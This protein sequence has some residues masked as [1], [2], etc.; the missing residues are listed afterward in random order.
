MARS[1]GG[2]T[3]YYSLHA[4]IP[5]A[6][7]SNMKLF[8]TA[9]ALDAL[10]ADYEY[11]TYLTL[12]GP[13]E[14]G[15]LDGHLWVTGRGDPS[16]SDR[17][18]GDRDAMMKRWAAELKR[19]GIRHV[20]GSVVGDDDYFDDVMRHPE[21]KKSHYMEWYGA[22]V[23][24]L[25]FNDNCLRVYWKP[26]PRVNAPALYS[27]DPDVSAM[28]LVN[29]MKT[30][31]AKGT[32][33]RSYLPHV[34][35]GTAEALGSI[36]I[37]RKSPVSDWVPVD[38]PTQFFAA[39]FRAVLV[40]EG[41]TV[42]GPGVD[43][44]DAK[45]K[46]G[47]DTPVRRVAVHKSPT[48]SALVRV[49]NRHSQNFYA[50]MLLKTVGRERQKMGS[51][52]AGRKAVGEFMKRWKIDS[53]GFRQED[54]S[55]LAATNAVTP[56]QFVDLLDVMD[57]HPAAEAFRDSLPV[58]GERGGSL[59]TRFQ[60]TREQKALASS[61]AAKTGSINSV[62]A[63]SGVC[64]P[65]GG[66]PFFFSVL[67]ND[68]PGAGYAGVPAIDEIATALARHAGESGNPQARN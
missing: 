46:V 5:R 52:E 3:T 66:E 24:A 37:T 59:R 51:Y 40:A 54:G 43:Q 9:V 36:R 67:L 49:T 48:L 7:A 17:F 50:E 53:K 25:S 58:G 6:P 61:I 57:K 47:P 63:L 8:T 28:A 68:I 4:D 39:A 14:D 42:D 21:W 2:A 60:K 55:G 45:I 26:G 23:S 62:R 16:I 32:E 38:N 31:S 22:P 15:V 41:I 11:S 19:L 65:E 29:G 33:R 20:T 34:G 18:E 10:G 30:A 44:D 1:P 35:S 13:V 56:R 12:V 64:R 27:I